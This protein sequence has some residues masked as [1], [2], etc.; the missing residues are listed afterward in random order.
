MVGRG[1]QAKGHAQ[2][3]R[4]APE[5]GNGRPK[6][7]E[8]KSRLVTQ[9]LRAKKLPGNGEPAVRAERGRQFIRHLQILAALGAAPHGLMA[10]ELLDA[11][12]GGRTL[13]TV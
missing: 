5:P 4:R 9:Q 6:T 3:K 13:R 2:A 8:S 10:H 1:T 12:G 11:T 7:I